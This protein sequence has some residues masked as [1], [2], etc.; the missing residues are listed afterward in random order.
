MEKRQQFY[1]NKTAPKHSVPTK[2]ITSFQTCRR[3]DR[4]RSFNKLA[5]TVSATAQ[6]S[7]LNYCTRNQPSCLHSKVYVTLT[8]SAKIPGASS[9]RRLE[10]VQ[11][12]IY[13]GLRVRNFMSAFWNT[14][15]CWA[16]T[17]IF[18]KFVHPCFWRCHKC[19]IQIKYSNHWLQITA[20]CY[21]LSTKARNLL[22]TVMQ[23]SG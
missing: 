6:Q 14:E 22:H 4:K 17:Q 16:A 5:V 12:L 11:R 7:V 8:R 21:A 3:S 18:G 15:K 2:T 1:Q 10:F 19:G 23:R 20:I 9:P 13:V